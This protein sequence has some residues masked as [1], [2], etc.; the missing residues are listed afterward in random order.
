MCWVKGAVAQSTDGSQ[1]NILHLYISPVEP[2]PSEQGSAA[3]CS[4]AA[5]APKGAESWEIDEKDIYE[6]E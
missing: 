2:L 6:G 1:V 4:G 3:A 5:G